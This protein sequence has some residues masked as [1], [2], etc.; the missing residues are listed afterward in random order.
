MKKNFYI[1]LILLLCA[2]HIISQADFG[3]VTPQTADFMECAE[4]PVNLYIGR[5]NYE[6]P[7]FTVKTA[8]FSMPISLCYETHKNIIIINQH[9]A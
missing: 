1:V 9:G 4:I 3:R 7:I 2:S 6:V 5:I 8:D